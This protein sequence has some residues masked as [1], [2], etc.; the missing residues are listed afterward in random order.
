MSVALGL[1]MTQ[2]RYGIGS[3][4]ISAFAG[5]LC[6]PVNTINK[7]FRDWAQ[8]AIFE[9]HNPDRS[10]LHGQLYWQHLEKSVVAAEVQNRNWQQRDEASAC[11]KPAVQV[12][13]KRRNGRTR[14]IDATGTK[15]L[16]SNRAG[17]RVGRR[18][19][20]RFA[21]QIRKPKAAGTRPFAFAG[22][23]HD[24]LIVVHDIRVQIVLGEIR[25]DA[26]NE[27]INAAL[28]Q[29]AIIQCADDS[30]G[31]VK[32]NPGIFA[33]EPFDDSR[34]QAGRDAFCAAD[35]QFSYGRVSEKLRAP[36][37]FV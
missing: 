34:Q 7:P 5:R 22:S 36:P 16:N 17:Q 2:S 15:Q 18:Q 12:Y 3:S 10:R 14:H 11:S 27:Q 29:L 33:R 37:R 19:N 13:R 26:S 20:P 1:F 21:A 4:K 28:P 25:R 9:R 8:C 31:N 32:A 35:A 23:H 24:D 6:D 30:L